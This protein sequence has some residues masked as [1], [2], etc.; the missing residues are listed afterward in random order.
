MQPKQ[1]IEFSWIY[2]CFYLRKENVFQ[3]KQVFKPFSP[4]D[5]EECLTEVENK[6]KN[7][8]K[9]QEKKDEVTNKEEERNRSTQGGDETCW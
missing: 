7:K 1:P 2:F 3:F 8:R 4:D 5:D 9:N 6:K